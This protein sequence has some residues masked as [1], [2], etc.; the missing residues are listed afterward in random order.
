M[1]YD[2]ERR[3]FVAYGGL[4]PESQTPLRNHMSFFRLAEANFLIR[5]NFVRRRILVFQ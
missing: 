2:L 3:R 1:I 5:S 4:R